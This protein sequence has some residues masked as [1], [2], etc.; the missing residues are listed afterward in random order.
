MKVRAGFV[1]NSSSSSFMIAIGVIF[2]PEKFNAWLKKLER[3][4]GGHVIGLQALNASELFDTDHSCL[5]LKENNVELEAPINDPVAV[6]VSEENIKAVI[7]TVPKKILAKNL[8]FDHDSVQ[9][10]VY[11]IGN[12]E[13][14]SAFSDNDLGLDYD[15]GFDWF[16]E[17]QQEIYNGFDESN[18][19][20]Y[21][22]KRFGAGR[23]G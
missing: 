4:G 14:D 17:D 10:A 20:T 12:D 15:I 5:S 7:E 18:G 21:I 16:T 6:K 2:D 23:N 3:R 13:G 9:L 1:S 22:D 19:I 11:I 8:L